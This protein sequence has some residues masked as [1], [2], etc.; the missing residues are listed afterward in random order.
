ME[1]EN[2]LHHH[3]HQTPRSG[4]SHRPSSGGYHLQLSKNV[5]R[6][7]PSSRSK[8]TPSIA[9][10]WSRNQRP[11]F[12]GCCGFRHVLAISTLP[13]RMHLPKKREKEAV[14]MWC[15]GISHVFYR[16]IK[17]ISKSQQRIIVYLQVERRRKTQVVFSE[18]P[19]REQQ[20][21]R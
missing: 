18:D 7:T 13:A 5:Q 9:T 19:G 3:P 2:L 15:D 6:S 20:H 10:L 17:A 14:S 8:D 1:C 21:C 16:S 11:E 4:L 12:V